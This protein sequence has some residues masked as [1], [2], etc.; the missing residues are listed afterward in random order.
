MLVTDKRL[1]LNEAVQ[2]MGFASVEDF[3]L[4]KTKETLLKE[5]S[6]SIKM[7]EQL[8]S[9]YGLNYLDFCNKFHSLAQPVF[10]KEEDGAEWN[11]ELKQRELLLQKLL[12]LE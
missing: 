11:A 9:K 10:E 12:R 8:E 6:E 3:A 1:A 2:Q 4:E 5:I 7:T